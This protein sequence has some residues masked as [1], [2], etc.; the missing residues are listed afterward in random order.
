[1]FYIYIDWTLEEIA[2]PF[3]VGKGLEARTR[4]IERNKKHKNVRNKWGYRREI[5]FQSDNEQECF[6]KEIETIAQYHTYVQDCDSSE[7]ACNFT[8]GGD[9]ATGFVRSIETRQKISAALI[10]KPNLKNRRENNPQRGQAISESLKGRPLSEEHKRATAEGLV[11]YYATHEIRHTEESKRNMAAAQKIIGAKKTEKAT[12][13]PSHPDAQPRVC[14][15]CNKQY[16]PKRLIRSQIARH[17]TKRWCSRSCALVAH[18]K[19]S[20]TIY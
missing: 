7:I 6:S 11:K 15:V 19:K 14:P 10:G 18:N 5:V 1:M 20:V 9:G 12:V 3:Y 17:I 8:K 16:S 2:R 4:N 13:D